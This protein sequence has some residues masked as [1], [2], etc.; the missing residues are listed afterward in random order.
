MLDEDGVLTIHLVRHGETVA[1]REH[2]LC[3]QSDCALSE[4]GRLQS[5]AIVESCA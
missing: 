4:R 1:T 2:R 3:G 5:E